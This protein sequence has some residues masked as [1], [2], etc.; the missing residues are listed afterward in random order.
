MDD[1][2]RDR[3]NGVTALGPLAARS[4]G[5]LAAVAAADHWYRRPEQVRHGPPLSCLYRVT[6]RRPKATTS[7]DVLLVT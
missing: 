1:R 6:F 5:G 7:I 4:P 2:P 3:V